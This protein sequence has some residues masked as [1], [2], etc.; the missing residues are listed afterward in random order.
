MCG[1]KCLPCSTKVHIVGVL[2]GSVKYLT[3]EFCRTF[4]YL[5]YED[6]FSVG[7]TLAFEQRC[8]DYLPIIMLRVVVLQFEKIFSDT[9]W[10]LAP[11]F[12]GV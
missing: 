8:A 10:A 3:A 6:S 5:L 11:A 4:Q 2:E 1:A 12:N 7:N 9:L